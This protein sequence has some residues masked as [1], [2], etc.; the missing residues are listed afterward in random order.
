VGIQDRVVVPTI[1]KE[2]AQ[3]QQID[4]NA[5]RAFKGAPGSAGGTAED[6][7]LTRA[8]A[9]PCRDA[10]AS[11]VV[12][13]HEGGSLSREAQAGLRRTMEK[14]TSTLR[15]IICCIATSNLIAPIRSRC[16]LVRVAAPSEA[17]VSGVR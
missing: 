4:T 3:T 2:I 14:Y 7:V 12:V 17:E 16:V 5:P 1:I 11:P 13:I 6:A 10:R 8:R 9:T 15:I